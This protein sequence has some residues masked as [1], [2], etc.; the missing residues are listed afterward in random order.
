MKK[1]F[2]KYQ[3][4]LLSSTI[5]SEIN[6]VVYAENDKINKE[7]DKDIDDYGVIQDMSALIDA[8]KPGASQ[9]FLF[10]S[11]KSNIK[12]A[13]ADAHPLSSKKKQAIRTI[14]V[15]HLIAKSM[16]DDS[17]NGNDIYTALIEEAK[18]Q[19]LK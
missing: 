4:E 18:K 14:D 17:E 13:F 19:F 1:N 5:A 6:K 3:V 9:G 16:L 8:W 15:N 7:I 12:R 2:N 11:V 10:E